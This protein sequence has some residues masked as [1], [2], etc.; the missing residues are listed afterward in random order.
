MIRKLFNRVLYRYI[1]PYG[2]LLIVK[3]L[4]FT[5]RLKIMAPENERDVIARH[6]SIIYVSW[7]QRFFPGISFFAT[8]RPI[9]IMISQSRDGNYI[10][11]IVNILGWHAVRGSSSRG[12]R[13]A[14]Q[15]LK[16]HALAGSKIGH[17]VDGPRGPSGVVKPGVLRI[18]QVAQLPMAPTI[19]SGQRRW[20][21]RSWDRFMIPKPFSRV[22]IRFGAP[23]YVPAELDEAEFE[24]KRLLLQEQM[25]R[26]YQDTDR[27]W[28]SPA[29]IDQIF[30]SRIKA[31]LSKLADGLPTGGQRLKK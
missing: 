20:V 3:L 13:D 7:H 29:A 23:I 31:M 26:L 15:A 1:I 24:Q 17:I 16:A 30:P 6:G 10:A 28:Q 11:K 5:Y 27:I 14:L 22:I 9:A 4:S 25:H 19:T 2:G 21:F 18:A 8:R 12:G